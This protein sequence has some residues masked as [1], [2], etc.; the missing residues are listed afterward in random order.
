MSN[1]EVNS[2]AV[3]PQHSIITST[4]SEDEIQNNLEASKDS[5]DREPNVEDSQHNQSLNKDNVS[6]SDNYVVRS[7]SVIKSP[8]KALFVSSSTPV[9]KVMDSSQEFSEKENNNEVKRSIGA[10]VIAQTPSQCASSQNSISFLHS[11][12]NPTLANPFLRTSSLS[13]NFFNSPDNSD[14]NSDN[15][16]SF[17]PSKLL[18]PFSSNNPFEASTTERPSVLR[19]ADSNAEGN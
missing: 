17:A 18:S 12:T 15:S 5:A 13:S 14:L 1:P 8:S 9:I 4:T 10:S 7:E 6:E 3:T 11:A 16:F 19:A 2:S